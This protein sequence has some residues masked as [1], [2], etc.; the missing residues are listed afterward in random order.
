[1]YSNRMRPLYHVVLPLGDRQIA[2]QEVRARIA[3]DT[4]LM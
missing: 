3:A 2:G 1:M 4:A